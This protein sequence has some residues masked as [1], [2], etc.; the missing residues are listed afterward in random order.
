MIQVS[1]TILGLGTPL[2]LTVLTVIVDRLKLFQTLPG[3]GNNG[4]C[5]L[6]ITGAKVTA[7]P[8]IHFYS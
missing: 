7:V 4:G 3:V 2:M 6:S 1:Y 5:F 8:I